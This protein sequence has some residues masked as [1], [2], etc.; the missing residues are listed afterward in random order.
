MYRSVVSN[1]GI[2]TAEY[3]LMS[4]RPSSE[5]ASHLESAE[6]DPNREA[7]NQ[8]CRKSERSK[9][10]HGHVLPPNAHAKNR[11]RV[12]IVVQDRRSRD[13]G[14]L[15]SSEIIG[16]SVLTPSRSIPKAVLFGNPA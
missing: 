1:C 7:A 8:D 10:L 2:G 9:R 6:G 3:G 12:R 15:Q 13:T 11:D 14:K 5:T 16:S 4:K